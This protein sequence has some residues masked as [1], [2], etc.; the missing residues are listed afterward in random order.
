ME[1]PLKPQ[2]RISGPR[3]EMKNTLY[4]LDLSQT[5]IFPWGRLQPMHGFATWCTGIMSAAGVGAVDA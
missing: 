5:S 3:D 1:L 4:T 2:H